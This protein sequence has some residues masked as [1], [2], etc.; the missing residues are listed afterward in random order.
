M[1][2]AAE[3]IFGYEPASTHLFVL[4]AITT[5]LLGAA[6]FRLRH[7]EFPTQQS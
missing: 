6:V 2:G 7:T 5:G 3:N 4:F 1:D